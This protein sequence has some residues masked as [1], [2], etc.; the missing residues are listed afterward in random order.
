M[1]SKLFALVLV[2][3]ASAN[4]STMWAYD[5]DFKVDSLYYTITSDTTVEIARD[6]SY[7]AWTELS[8][9]N[10]VTHDGVEY[11]VTGIA[12]YAF[13]QCQKLASITFPDNL[14]YIGDYSFSDCA[15]TELVIPE[16]V[17]SIRGCA[18]EYCDQITSVSLPNSLQEIQG[19]AFYDD[20][21]NRSKTI[22]DSIL[23]YG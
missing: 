10:K 23:F 8:L 2:C 1:K 15:F 22:Q 12:Q 14:V 5:Y 17:T 9:P 4:L 3:I 13:Y 7:K 18:F 19:H 11:A 20:C 16:K 6:D 21:T